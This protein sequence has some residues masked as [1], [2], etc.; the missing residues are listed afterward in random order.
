LPTVHRIFVSDSYHS[1]VVVLHR[2]R[3]DDTFEPQFGGLGRTVIPLRDGFGSATDVLPTPDGG[4][5]VHAGLFASWGQYATF[6]K[7]D[8]RGF[9]D[10]SFGDAGYVRQFG[11]HYSAMLGW[12]A[13]PDGH[14]VYVAF[15][16][17]ETG[18]GRIYA[19][20]M[21]AIPDIVEF[22]NAITGHYFIAYDGLEASAI[23]DGAAGPGWCAPRWGSARAGR[24]PCAASTIRA[25][26]RISSRRS[27]RSA[28]R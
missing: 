27:P 10:R 14:L 13:Q 5:V 24:H 2:Y 22:R 28:K 17:R 23:D 16:V 7:I 6:H 19:T 21:R 4:F 1:D 20:R 12:T 11:E 15:S 8:A 3:P 9:V 18:T 26:I 25:R